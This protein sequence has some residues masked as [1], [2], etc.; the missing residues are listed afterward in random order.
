MLAQ[1]V[2]GQAPMLQHILWKHILHHHST[3][4]CQTFPELLNFLGLPVQ[5]CCHKV[6]CRDNVTPLDLLLS[7][8]TVLIQT[9]VLKSPT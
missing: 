1:Q 8:G 6:R 3:T 9:V 7:S 2:L 5:H 4:A